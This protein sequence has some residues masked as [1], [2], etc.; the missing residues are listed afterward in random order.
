MDSYLNGLA[1]IFLQKGLSMI[2]LRYKLN[3]LYIKSLDI[4]V[5]KG[6]IGQ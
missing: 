5:G 2:L 3:K 6:H 4:K 1:K